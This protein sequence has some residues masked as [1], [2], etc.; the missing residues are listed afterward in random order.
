MMKNT[1]T[2]L[3]DSDSRKVQATG[4]V[5]NL[6]SGEVLPENVYKCVADFESGIGEEAIGAIDSSCYKFPRIFDSTGAPRIQ[7][8]DG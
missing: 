8:G 4:E 3:R 5:M 7:K 1:E 6:R 2:R